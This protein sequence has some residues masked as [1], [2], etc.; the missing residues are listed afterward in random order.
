MW[1]CVKTQIKTLVRCRRGV[2]IFCGLMIL[3][4][5]NYLTNV[6]QYRGRDLANMYQ[7]MYLLTLASSNE[8]AYGFYFMQ[9]FPLLAPAVAGF[10]Y[11]DARSAGME[12]FWC[13][14]IGRRRYFASLSVAVFLTTFLM[15]T[16]PFLIEIVLNC[17]AFPLQAVGTPFNWSIYNPQYIALVLDY[18][19]HQ[20]YLFS[21]CLY[22]ML[23]TLLFGAAAGIL[24]VFTVA[25]STFRIKFKVLLLLPVFL[26]LYLPGVLLPEINYFFYLQLFTWF[27][28]NGA[29][30]SALFLAVLAVSIGLLARRCREDYL[31]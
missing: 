2:F 1:A 19:L 31:Q 28:G 4:L 25:V 18:P 12:L 11:F 6:F 14:R 24:A 15:F 8:H 13:A 30:W 23:F 27:G 26:L 10:A 9:V 16:I 17:L 3:V 20:V 5:V 21:P 7:P 29:L 22:A